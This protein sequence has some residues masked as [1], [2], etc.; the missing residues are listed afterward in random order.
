MPE[1]VCSSFI[2]R[3]RGKSTPFGD[4]ASSV[5]QGKLIFVTII[6]IYLTQIGGCKLVISTAFMFIENKNGLIAL[7]T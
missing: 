4:R 6:M 2:I 5:L 1:K 3:A 7:N